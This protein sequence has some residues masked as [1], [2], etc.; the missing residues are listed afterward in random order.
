MADKVWAAWDDA[1]MPEVPGA[2]AAL[3]SFHVKRA[4]IEFCDSSLAWRKAV[5]SISSVSGTGEYTLPDVATGVAVS[6][7]LEA[8]WQG[9][10]LTFLRPDELAA[11]YGPTD[12]RGL[13]GTPEYFTQETAGTIRLVPAPD[14][15]VASGINGLFAAVRPKDDAT[16][17]EDAFASDWF[18]AIAAGAKRNLM[19]IPKK[20]YTDLNLAA[21]Y[22]GDFETEIGAAAYA[23]FRGNGPSTSRTE[24]NFR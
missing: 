2:P 4:A 13:T 6:R 17:L 3:V 12:W 16:G 15:T 11:V 7:L 19:R 22:Q 20:P 21:A 1:V 18:D 9:T 5:P 10:K 14:A 8:R 24:T 23:A